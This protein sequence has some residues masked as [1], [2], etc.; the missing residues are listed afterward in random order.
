MVRAAA[1]GRLLRRPPSIIYPSPIHSRAGRAPSFRRVN[2]AAREGG[3]LAAT[4]APDPRAARAS[5]RVAE[6]LPF[7]ALSGRRLRRR[8]LSPPGPRAGPPSS[9]G[10][11]AYKRGSNHASPQ[12][13]LSPWSSA[14]AAV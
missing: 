13:V 2:A 10:L 12:D 6:T 8:F 3:E 5:A 14:R 4:T 11:A 9:S 1:A 7:S